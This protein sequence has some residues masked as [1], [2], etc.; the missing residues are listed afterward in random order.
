MKKVNKVVNDISVVKAELGTQNHPE[1]TEWQFIP[2]TE[3][4]IN[5]S[6][7]LF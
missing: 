2:F 1:K 6:V 4:I 3:K 5:S 7:T